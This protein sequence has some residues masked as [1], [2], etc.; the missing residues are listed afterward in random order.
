M[1]NNKELMKNYR[2][3]YTH[4]LCSNVELYILVYVAH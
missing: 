4:I 1:S 3:M 2:R